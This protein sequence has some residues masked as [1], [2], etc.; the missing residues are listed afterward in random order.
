MHHPKAVGDE[1]ASRSDQFDQL[2]GQCPPVVIVLAGFAFV[3]ADVLQQQDVAAGE[4]LGAGQRIGADNVSSQLDVP[5]ELLTQRH[6]DRRQRQCRVRPVLGTSQ[7]RG[8]HHL[9]VGVEQ[10]L[11]RRRRR[12]DAARIGNGAVLVE[13]NV[14]IGAH[15]HSTP[16]NTFGE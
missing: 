13:R 4:P 3:E 8:N 6:G 1:N 16:R 2:L 5:A 10:R 7:V 11:Q 9:G 12:D 15:Q 14:E